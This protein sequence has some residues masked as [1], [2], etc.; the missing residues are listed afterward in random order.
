MSGFETSDG[1]LDITR[2]GSALIEL[3]SGT[4][5]PV[6][7]DE[8][9]S[10][11]A[12][13]PAA[14][15]AYLD[16]FEMT[17]MLEAE[18]ETCA[19]SGSLPT[20]IAD[21][22][23]TARLFRRSLLAAAAVVLFAAVVATLY[24][25]AQ[26]GVQE[27]ALTAVASSHWSVD[28]EVGD[29]SKRQATLREGGT[30]RLESG[31]LELQL[32]SGAAMVMHG[33]AE[34]SFPKIHQPVI[35]SGWLWID[36]GTARESFD[37]RTPD[38]GIRNLGTRF[39]VRVPEEGPAEVHLIT[40][41]L[42]V[43]PRR[44][45]GKPLEV[46]TEG[47]AW[48]IPLMGE[49]SSRPV[50]DDPFP[51][52]AE[53]LAAQADYSL[54]VRG[55]NPTGYWRL[56]HPNNGP[57]ANEV[58]GRSAGRC[59]LGA[60]SSPG[61]GPAEGFAGFA[62]SNTAV[63][64][65]GFP[66]AV[67]LSL[68]ATQPHK[69]LL[70]HDVFDGAGPLHLRFP[71]NSPAETGWVAAPN[72]GGN[73]VI[74]PGRGSATLAFA[75]MGGVVYTLEATLQDVTTAVGD[76]SWVALGFAGGQ[77]TGR[78]T[79]DRFIDGEVIGRAWML[80]R[81]A[82]ANSANTAL[83]AGAS[84]T[85]PWN[86]WTHGSGGAIDL[87]I[88]LDTTGGAGTWTATWFARR[89]GQ[90]DYIKVRDTCRLPNESIQSVGIATIGGRERGRISRFS[91]RAAPATADHSNSVRADGPARIT[92]SR[93]TV[94]WW[95]RREP[96]IEGP[97]ILWSAGETS[98]DSAVF[99]RLKKDGRVGLFIE[100]GRYDVLL[101]SEQDIADG[102]WH[103]LVASWGPMAAALYLDGQRI[104][105]DPDFQGLQQE[106][107]PELQVGGGPPAAGGAPFTGWIDEIAC[108][109]RALTPIEVEQQF[110]SALG[111]APH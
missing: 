13:S 65:S 76:D 19:E 88:V 84:D 70:F 33:P 35:R 55:Q 8:L 86:G 77:S 54:T 72:F 5:D 44:E 41:K 96:G 56:E 39:G 10:L 7:R 62:N 107:L 20:I 74:S 18:A 61:P 40:G 110:Q 81:G 21:A 53:L 45:T 111:A 102:R 4:L 85:K 14:Q 64:L 108:W 16:Y 83:L 15:R 60:S 27:L 82:G 80:F 100:N 93:G 24:K 1:R 69:G 48:A 91:L 43:T 51:G 68:G 37:V 89:P 52:I 98:T 97:E 29:Q 28:G 63:G 106:S 11:I 78:G 23:Q 67:P 6:E 9:M 22:G 30:V 38:L 36:S 87:R 71:K 42:Q 31:T 25:V 105:H 66:D 79:G 109:D 17:A 73:G 99:A 3:E 101:S 49:T 90:H 92:R 2:L 34:V 32:E 12:R 58:P 103:H 75:P 47:Q 46:T 50:A 59:R 94:S 95:L 104:A 57:L 26:P